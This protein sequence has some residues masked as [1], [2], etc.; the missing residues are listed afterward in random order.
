MKGTAALTALNIQISL[1]PVGK[2]Y[3]T[4]FLNILFTTKIN[5]FKPIK[6]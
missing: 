4:D 3:V 1:H 2:K 6:L 5:Q